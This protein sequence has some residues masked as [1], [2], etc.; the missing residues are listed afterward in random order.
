MSPIFDVTANENAHYKC[1]ELEY[2][3]R[4]KTAKGGMAGL[5]SIRNY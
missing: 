2:M 4:L 5:R 1:N 3:V